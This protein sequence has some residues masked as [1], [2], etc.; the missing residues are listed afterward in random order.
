ML[1][2]YVGGQITNNVSV[3]I[4]GA[5]FAGLR[6]AQR[7]EELGIKYTVFEG[8]NRVGGRVYPF[9]YWN[10]YLQHGAEYVNGEDNEIYEIVKKNNL[11]SPTEIDEEGYETVV[12]GREVNNKLY[13]IW[14]KFESSTNEKL[15]RDGANKKIFNKTVSERIDFYFDS[16]LAPQ[17]LTQSEQ[18]VMQNM[19]KLFKNQYQMEWSASANDVRVDSEATLNQ[20]GFKSILDVL[21]SKVPVN[22]IKLSS[23]VVNIDYTGNKIKILLSYGQSYLFDSVI[24]TSS[25]GYLKQYKNSLFTPSLSATKSAAIERF[26]FGNNMK[27]FLEYSRPWW[28]RGMSTV[29]ISGR[30]GINGNGNSLEDELMVFQPSLWAS[31][32]L[33]VWIAGNGPRKVS[34]LTD[35]QLITIINN[36][37]TTNLKDVYTVSNIQRIYRHNWITDEFSLGSYS[38]ISNKTCSM[39]TDDLK[40]LRDPILV[41]RKPVICFAGEHTDTEMYQTVVGAARSGLRE[42]DRILNYY[43][44]L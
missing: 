29:Q 17:K 3:A 30:V 6:A 8:S 9:S 22:K 2:G 7:F 10:G 11:L 42:A 18:I 24:V 25:L 21:T 41:N 34:K 26:G 12:Y 36:H 39:N 1:F 33:V 40:L 35:S 32:I 38:Y 5:G 15:E 44:S 19:N 23:K 13:N 27:I 28:P 43:S 20:Y 4:I 37:L 16:F 31:N 14:D